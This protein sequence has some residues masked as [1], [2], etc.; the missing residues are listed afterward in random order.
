MKVEKLMLGFLF[1]VCMMALLNSPASGKTFGYGT[2]NPGSITY[3]VGSAVAKLFSEKADILTLVQ[4][5]GGP[6]AFVPAVNAGE[7]DFCGANVLDLLYA[8]TGDE[9]FKGQAM[10]DLRVVSVLLPMRTAFYVRKDSSYKSIKDL[11]G[12]RFPS[13]YKAQQVMEL[14]ATS[15]LANAGLTWNDVQKVPVPNVNR[16]ADDFM[17]G[18][19]EAFIFDITSGKVQ[20]VVSSVGGL[21]ALSLDPSPEAIARSRQH[22]PVIYAYLMQPSPA[23]TTIVEPTYVAAADLAL[24]ASVK[25]PADVIYRAAKVLYEGKAALTSFFKPFGEVF[26]PGKMAKILPKGEYH[27]GAI[28]FYKEMN[29]WPPKE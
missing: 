9:Y 4:P 2:G 7:L 29:M 6:N 3:S 15:I 13:D 10:P 18:K 21:R 14:T 22:M 17:A 19:A 8:L 24:L 27:E 12:K 26:E 16:G 25:Q 1:G 11:R 28:K 5:H 20:E 23:L